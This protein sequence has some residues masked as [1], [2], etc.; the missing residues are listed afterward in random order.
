MVASYILSF[1]V[2]PAFSRFILSDH[3]HQEG[4]GKGVF[5]AFERGFVRLRNAYGRALEAALEQ[6]KFVLVCVGL[7]LLLTAAAR[8]HH[9]HG[10]LPHRRRRHHQAALPRARG[11][12]H[13]GNRAAGAGCRTPHPPDHSG[14]RAAHHQ[15]HDRHSDLLQSGAGADRQCQRHGCGNPDLSSARATNRRP[16]TCARCANSC[17]PRSR[18]H[19]LFPDRRYRQPG[20]EFR[21][22]RAAGC[23]DS[24]RRH[25]QVL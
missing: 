1:T 25:Q 23:A 18:A 3:V 14:G 2:V 19:V 12:P 20:A 24:G 6:R 15:R 22:G 11:Y 10:L 17:R 5:G 4:E 13:R 8:H 7:L 9:R 16:I 21:P